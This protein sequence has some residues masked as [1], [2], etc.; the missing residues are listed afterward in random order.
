MNNIGNFAYYKKE[1]V[2]CIFLTATELLISYINLTMTTSQEVPY[3][4]KARRSII[5]GVLLFILSC[6]VPL[7]LYTTSIHRAELPS[8][9]VE[10]KINSFRDLVRFNIPVYVRIDPSHESLVQEWQ[11]S[12]DSRNNNDGLGGKWSLQLKLQDEEALK[13]EVYTLDVNI[14]STSDQN[15]YKVSSSSGNISLNVEPTANGSE[16]VTNVLLNSIFGDE[17]KQILS[18]L[19]IKEDEKDSDIVFPYSNTYNVVFNLFVENGRPVEWDVES[20]IQAMNPVFDALSNYANFKISTQV[21]LYS[22]LGSSTRYAE[23]LK[24]NIIPKSELSTFINFGDWNL[25]THDINPSINFILYFSKS[26]YEKVPLLVEGSNTNS[27]LIPQ[28]GGVYIYNRKMPIINDTIFKLNTY[29]LQPIFEIF[30]SQLFELLGVPKNSESP[31]IRIDSLNRV[32]ALKN[33]KRSLENLSSLIKLSTSLNEI[34]IPE[35][36]KFHT[37]QAL[38]Y[39]DQAMTEL[40]NSH[41]EEAIVLASKSVESSDKAFFE[42]EMV[43]QAYFPSEHKLA[44][45]SPLLGPLCTIVLIGFLSTVKDMKSKK[46]GPKKV[47]D[48]DE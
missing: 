14:V 45:F 33:L 48:K 41:F 13:N 7:F 36:T 46:Q 42:K 21:Q 30:T 29:E 19:G 35:S 26:N 37:E 28:W 6:G 38:A 22:K 34:S 17:R 20:A 18:I 1:S 40:A 43:Q 47:Q 2:R 3:I 10:A 8:H 39:Y 25:I 31:W 44:V 23:D 32:I 9:E 24:A 4:T 5:F 11:D 16:F 15:T 12:L 27:F